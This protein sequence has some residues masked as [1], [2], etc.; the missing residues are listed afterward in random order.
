MNKKHKT[1]DRRLTAVVRRA[2]DGL[3]LLINKNN[4]LDQ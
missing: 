3:N 2:D 4:N 1:I